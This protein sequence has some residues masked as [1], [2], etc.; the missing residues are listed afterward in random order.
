[1]AAPPPNEGR[2]ETTN[3]FQNTHRSGLFWVC[4]CTRSCD[5]PLSRSGVGATARLLGGRYQVRSFRRPCTIAPHLKPYVGPHGP[6]PC[7]SSASIAPQAARGPL[8]M[9]GLGQ[10]RAIWAAGLHRSWHRSLRARG[11]GRRDAVLHD[12]LRGARPDEKGS[13]SDVCAGL[14]RVVVVGKPGCCRGRCAWRGCH[15]PPLDLSFA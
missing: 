1:V 12:V 15:C 6:S 5:Y 11:S 2:S 4:A 8:P 3:D 13:G 9:R 10:R 14:G 7:A